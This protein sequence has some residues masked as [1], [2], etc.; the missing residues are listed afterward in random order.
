M[1]NTLFGNTRWRKMTKII[2]IGGAAGTGKTTVAQELCQKLEID[3][4]IATGFIR[5]TI[6]VTTDNKILDFHTYSSTDKPP[7]EHLLEQTKLMKDAIN[8]CI[9]RCYKEGTSL[10]IE[11]SN[12]IPGIINNKNV[13]TFVLLYVGDIEKHRK[14]VYGKTH[15]KRTVNEEEFNRNRE[16]QSTLL[17]LAKENDVTI[18]EGSQNISK[19]LDGI[20]K[21]LEQQMIISK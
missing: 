15:T 18:I 11:G 17:E 12:L 16:I 6:R 21:T 3:H 8:A 9:D 13:T 10:I 4:R 1:R 19:I 2:L 14:M 5:E 20:S 7:F